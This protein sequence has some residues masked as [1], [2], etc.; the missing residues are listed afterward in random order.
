MY[1]HWT[2]S[3]VFNVA[4]HVSTTTA[5]MLSLEASHTKLVTESG[6]SSCYLSVRVGHSSLKVSAALVTVRPPEV[7][8]NHCSSMQTATQGPRKAG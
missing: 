1:N 3:T 8:L 2:N 6:Q 7:M 5:Q 4:M